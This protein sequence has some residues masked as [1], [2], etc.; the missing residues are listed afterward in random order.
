MPP[1][2]LN[3]RKT[4]D[5]RDVVHRAV[6]AIAE[7]K[8]VV[9]PTE[10]VYGLGASA[11]SGDAVDAVY[12][13][14]QR[15]A[16]EPLAL[17]LRSSEDLIDYSPRLGRKARRLAQ[18][19]WP[20]PVTLVV[21]VEREEGLFRQLPEKVR[22]AVAPQDEIGARVPAH[23]TFLD[24][25]R[26]LAGPIVLTSANLSGQPP[27]TTAE[28][29]VA[30]LGDK[31][32][33]VIDDGPCRYGQ[34]STV[35]RVGGDGFECLREGVVPL[36]AVERL[37]GMMIVVVCTGNTCRSPMAEALL[38]RQLAQRVGC[39]V[40]QLEQRG[41]GV[42]SAGVSASAGGAASPEAVEVMQQQGLDISSHVSRPLSE[43]LVRH[44][45]VI[46][47]LTDAHRQA[48]CQRWPGAAS[49]IATL[50]VDGRDVEDPFGS[51]AEAYRRCAAEIEDAVRERVAAMELS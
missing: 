28:Q 31:V 14:K 12:A 42:A 47:T 34:A 39:E 7:G 40:E 3:L 25:L 4:D 17:A 10:T 43:K 1:V 11:L 13:A 9:F 21:P 49:R 38:R 41:V 36:S 16:A 23:D 30:S 50:R 6:Q 19:C 33:L 2:V 37:A 15:V 18:R 20:G 27:A 45:D 29:A 22:Q 48:I 35:V 5:R 32:A 51:T 24:I 46:L 8:L 26:M 44:A